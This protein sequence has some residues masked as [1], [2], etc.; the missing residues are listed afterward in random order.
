V[1]CQAGSGD[2]EDCCEGGGV[3]LEA[4]WEITQRTSNPILF[5]MP[6][7]ASTLFG[8]TQSSHVSQKGKIIVSVLL[9]DD[10]SSGWSVSC[11]N[12]RRFLGFN[13]K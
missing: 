6:L 9:E 10:S 4:A 3:A 11:V 12:P 13:K 7:L 1:G 5:W 2:E 8:F